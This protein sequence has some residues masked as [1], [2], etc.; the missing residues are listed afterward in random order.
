MEERSASV[1]TA[2]GDNSPGHGIQ[3][4]LTASARPA[5][6]VPVDNSGARPTFPGRRERTRSRL[7]RLTGRGAVPYSPILEPLL[8]TVRA[9]NPKED[10]DLIQ[11]AFEVAEQ[12][13]RGQKRKSGDPYI[14]HPVAVATI[15]AE[16]GLSGT[17]LAAALLHDTVEDTPYTL[18]DL[19]KDFGPEVAML[20]DG[21]TKL[22]KVS[23]GEAAQSETVRK[24]VVA[25]A[26]DIRVLMIKLADR[27]HNARTWRF[28]SA[29]SSARK[30]RETLE[31]F[32]PL[33]HR[34]GMNTIKWELEDLSFAAL[35]PKVYEE[36]VRMVGD[37]TPEREKSLGVIRDQITD[38]LRTARIK[39]TITGRPKHYYSIYQKMIVRDKDFDDINDL[40]GVR[41]LVDSVRDCYAAL[42]TMHSRWNPLPGRF[43]DYIAM[44]KFNMYQSLHT[45]VIGPGGKP[46]EIQIRTHEMHRRAEYGVA[47]HWKY[48]DQP[49][50]TA[51][52][53]GS[54]RDG[55]MG[56]L[57]SLV[58][59]QQETSDPGEFLDSLRFEINA[60][61]VFV[62]TPKGEVMA[63]PAGSTPVDFAYAVHTEVG[64]R[65]IGA[66]VNGKLVPL[67]SELNHGD[68]VEIFTSKAE[69]AGP[70]QDWQHFVK[71]ARAR[72]KIRQWFSKER[73][74]E[75]IDRGK[76]LLTRAMRK[77]NLPLQRLMTHEA[78][79]A[80]AA[81]FKYV[82]IS[83]LYAGVGDGHTSA[84]SVMEKLVESLGGNE[85]TD[86][87]ITEVSIPTQVAKTKFSDS[88]VVVRGVGDVWVKL[89]RCCT[90]VPPDPILGFVTRGSGVSVHRTDCTN[91]S[92]LRDQPDR[93]VEVDWAPT[94]SSVFLVEIQVE[95]LDRKSL[96]SDV[97]RVLSENH[98]N[99]L[100]ASVNTSTDRVAI[101]RFAFE[102]GDPKYLSHVLSAVRRI[103][104]VFDVYRTTGNKRRS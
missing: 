30:A 38:D 104:G 66:R 67:N 12:S 74:E 78:L 77:Q 98:V 22:D 63:L 49:N 32:A 64:H 72:N 36:I 5:P 35:Y 44:P 29:E 57:R 7:A 73:R 31:I 81:E 24:M 99:I 10:F 76:E 48:K 26:K 19:K 60:R 79:A 6:A 34:L 92:D 21:V 102:M 13:H 51:V 11:R 69:G 55:D 27:L 86:D 16:L 1:P 4:G 3:T 40:M 25:M 71:S 96:L 52:G 15:L 101:S 42:G 39:A 68:W 41:V 18:A 84:Q 56:W 62:F 58:D 59:W 2:D 94:Q 23:F 43:K 103:D 100:A 61:E 85:S 14:T 9:N 50:R 97:T 89:A 46:V 80:V 28:V 20:V 8:R 82:D 75:A 47:A 53:P 83:G 54:P 45:T 17:T 87:D 93:I 88:G 70:S 90:P 33:A 65:T 95:A 91:I 37:R